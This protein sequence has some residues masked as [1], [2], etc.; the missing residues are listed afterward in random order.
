ME[1]IKI[2]HYHKFFDSFIDLP[3]G[4]QKKVI[5]FQEKFRKDSKSAAIHLEPISTF[6]DPTL[7]SARIDQAYR[8]ILKSFND[9]NI[10]YLLWVDHHDKA[11]QWA[12]NKVIDW[13][14]DTQSLQIF[15]NPEVTPLPNFKTEDFDVPGLFAE[16]SDKEL[17]R[18]GLPEIILP[19]VREIKVEHDLYELENFLPEG[20]YEQ[21]F[22]LAADGD[23]ERLIS[24]VEEGKVKEEALEKQL[25]SFNNQRSF[26]EFTD[27]N[28]FNEV[29]EGGLDKWKYYL[30]PEQRKIVTN[31]FSGS[32]KITGGAGTGKTVAAMH[33]L[34]FLVENSKPGEKILFT[35]FT[36]AL[37]NNLLGSTRGLNFNL[38]DVEI[39]NIDA[40]ALDLAKE[41][42]LVASDAKILEYDHQAAERLWEK[43]LNENLI[44]YGADFLEKEFCDVILNNNVSNLKDYLKTYRTG[45]GKPISRRQKKELWSHFEKFREIKNKENYFY[46]AELYNTLSDYLNEKDIRPY[47]HCLVDELQD[48]SNAELRL[49]RALVEEKPNDLFMVGDPLQK[50]YDRRINFSRGARINVRGKK[51]R[52][53]RVNYRTSEEIKR[54]AISIIKDISYDDFDGEEE[55]KA[56]YISLFHGV[57]PSYTTFK[58]KDQEINHLIERVQ[59]LVNQGYSLSELAITSRTKN[60]YKDFRSGLH[61]AGISYCEFQGGKKIGDAEGIPLLTFHNIKGLEFKQVFLVDVNERTCPFQ[62]PG[63]EYYTDEEKESHLRSER[64]LVYVAISRAIQNVEISGVGNKSEMINI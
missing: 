29:L 7:R 8:A 52:R 51:S 41:Y 15:D 53:L 14:V 27:N 26:I 46:K 49:V 6:K 38:S 33:R 9:G 31:N 20:V 64:S 59:T 28:V 21:L 50:I 45:M 23:I 39:R 3:K 1:G 25:E 16:Y 58:T 17:K 34:K 22:Y 4:I 48:F 43:L 12:E 11:Y 60:G 10:F 18:L 19:S 36:R 61:N 30:H 63:F 35:T 55:E 13:N 42:S 32:A 40:L 44:S 2:L 54:L 5:D 24:E 56:G 57:D 47:I 62:P 37:T